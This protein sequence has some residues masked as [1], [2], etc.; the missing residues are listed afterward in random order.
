LS[1]ASVPSSLQTYSYGRDCCDRQP[2]SRT[3]APGR[4]PVQLGL[5]WPA[6]AT[7]A[8]AVTVDKTPRARLLRESRS[9]FKYR[10]TQ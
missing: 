10:L 4:A 1:F 3:P 5:G 8:H 9:K 6:C 7:G 2:H